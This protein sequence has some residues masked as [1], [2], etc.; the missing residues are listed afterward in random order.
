MR[1]VLFAIELFDMVASFVV[2]TEV[3][4]VLLF[5]K[6]G[7]VVPGR[8]SL[9]ASGMDLALQN[10]DCARNDKERQKLQPQ[11]RAQ[12]RKLSHVPS[13]TASET[14]SKALISATEGIAEMICARGE[15]NENKS[16]LCVGWVGGRRAL[17]R[18]DRMRRGFQCSYGGF[19]YGLETPFGRRVFGW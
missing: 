6:D 7:I 16:L 2:L 8:G 11:G 19:I 1:T 5:V 13:S 3:V 15:N 17:L 14:T 12:R 18:K 10:V 4:F 9:G